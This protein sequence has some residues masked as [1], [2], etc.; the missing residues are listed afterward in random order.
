MTSLIAK[1][2]RVTGKTRHYVTE[3]EGVVPID[4]IPSQVEIRCQDVGVLLISIDG[5]GVEISD[6]WHLSVEEAKSQAEFEF[7]IVDDEWVSKK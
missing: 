6:T 2:E 7:G 4:V 1:V 3:A 5:E